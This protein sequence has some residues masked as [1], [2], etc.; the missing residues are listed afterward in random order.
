M[1]SIKEQ[2][3]RVIKQETK[4]EENAKVSFFEMLTP[5][6][7]GGVV[8]SIVLGIPGI[9]LLLFLIPV[10]GYLA[11]ALV[12]QYYEKVITE[13]EAAKVGAFAGIIGGIFGILITM[14]IAI[15]YAN[16]AL[17]FFRTILD[18]SAADLVLLLSGLDPYLSL[19]TLRLRLI[20]NI[21]LGTVFGAIGGVLYTRRMQSQKETQTA[22][23]RAEALNADAK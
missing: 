19:S 7:A 12:R 17:M 21:L 13:Q 8:I 23:E 9:N 6:F 16:D 18:P 15:F 11:V 10:G 1:V 20:A 4:I 3:E 2:L 5:A 14:I 22:Q